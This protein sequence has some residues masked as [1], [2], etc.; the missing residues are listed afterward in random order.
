M[1]HAV[2]ELVAREAGSGARGV[3]LRNVRF[4]QLTGPRVRPPGHRV[5]SDRGGRRRFELLSDGALACS[6]TLCSG[7]GHLERRRALDLAM[8]WAALE[9]A[10]A[11]APFGGGSLWALAAGLREAAAGEAAVLVVGHDRRLHAA[12]LLSALQGGPRVVFPHAATPGGARRARRRHGR[13]D[14]AR[15]RDGAG[16]PRGPRACRRGDDLRRAEA[17]GRGAPGCARH[18]GD[19]GPEPPLLE[20]RREPVR[21]GPAA[22]ACARRDRAAT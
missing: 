4:R 17:V 8:A 1:L 12:A 2:I 13:A 6:G 3:V 20:E 7:R 22:G 18:G 21:R 11:R 14:P 15:R 16:G 5:A 19:D 9:A 10:E